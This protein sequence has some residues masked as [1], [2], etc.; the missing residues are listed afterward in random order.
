MMKKIS[1]LSFTQIQIFLW[2]LV[3]GLNFFYVFQTDDSLWWAFSNAL[4]NVL[5]SAAIVY[6]NALWLMPAFYKKKR[7]FL[8]GAVS[9]F[10]IVAVTFVRTQLVA[11]VWCY[12]KRGTPEFIKY[13][14]NNGP[15]FKVYL[16]IFLSTVMVYIF[17]IAFRYVLDFFTI[18]QQQE[19]LKKQHAEAQLNLLKAQVQPHFL[20]NTL[21]NIYYTAQ[22]ESPV[23]AELIERLSGIMRYFL[24]EG[25]REYILLNTELDFIKNYIALEKIRMRFPLKVS[26]NVVNVDTGAVKIPPMLLIPLVENVFKHGINK[27]KQDNF[28]TLDITKTQKLSFKVSN[29]IQDNG[30]NTQ[31]GTG[32]ANLKSRLNILYG[33]DYLLTEVKGNDIYSVELIIP[34]EKN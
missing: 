9:L 7:F 1:R 6:G 19:I 3:F 24:E 20:F 27:R 30:V 21:N 26:E 16:S 22:E 33:P 18:R 11:L 17:S 32:L 5:F 28:M 10:L 12:I 8:Y 4:A 34:Y 15:Q 13:G 25:S 31:Q 29:K 14:N 23:T 2:L